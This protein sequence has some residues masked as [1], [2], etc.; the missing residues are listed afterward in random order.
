[1][2]GIELVHSEKVVLLIQ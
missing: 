1:M 2:R